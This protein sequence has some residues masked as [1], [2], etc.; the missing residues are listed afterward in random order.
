MF[1]PAIFI[2]VFFVFFLST[3]LR[4]LNEYERGVIFRCW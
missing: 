2:I 3:A 1:Y 4:I